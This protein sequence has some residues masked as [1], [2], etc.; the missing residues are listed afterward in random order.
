MNYTYS[1]SSPLVHP[2]V[3]P[4]DEFGTILQKLNGIKPHQKIFIADDGRFYIGG[5]GAK[6]R[7]TFRS[8]A[9]LPARHQPLGVE[10]RFIDFLQQGVLTR[11]VVGNQLSHIMAIAKRLGLNWGNAHN[12]AEH[13]ELAGLMQDII[14]AANNGEIDETSLRED[15]VKSF[16]DHHED[17]LLG[18]NG[19]GCCVPCFP[20]RATWKD[21]PQRSSLIG[22]VKPIP[23]QEIPPV[24]PEQFPETVVVIPE[25]PQPKEVTLPPL[26]PKIEEQVPPVIPEVPLPLPQLIDPPEESKPAD[27][28]INNVPVLPPVVPEIEPHKPNRWKKVIG[29][30]ALTSLIALTALGT[31]ALTQRELPPFDAK[32]ICPSPTECSPCVSSS[33][34]SYNNIMDG[35]ENTFPYFGVLSHL[36]TLVG[37]VAVTALYF[38]NQKNILSKIVEL[39]PVFVVEE[40]MVDNPKLLETIEALK[41][42]LK[43]LKEE[44]ER[45]GNEHAS[46]KQAYDALKQEYDVLKPK[47]EALLE[48][49]ALL[50]EKMDAEKTQLVEKILEARKTLLPILAQIRMTLEPKRNL[51]LTSEDSENQGINDDLTVT[52]KIFNFA[53]DEAEL[54][55]LS[56]RDL[57]V[58]FNLIINAGLS[59]IIQLLSTRNA[60]SEKEKDELGDQMIKSGLS[61]INDSLG[62]NEALRSMFQFLYNWLIDQR[63]TIKELL[64]LKLANAKTIGELKEQLK[65]YTSPTNSRKRQGGKALKIEDINITPDI[66]Q[67]LEALE[68]RIS[69][70]SEDEQIGI[71]RAALKRII[72]KSKA[73]ETKNV[74]IKQIK[75]SFK[76]GSESLTATERLKFLHKGLDFSP[77]ED[78]YEQLT[79]AYADWMDKGS[80]MTTLETKIEQFEQKISQKDKEIAKLIKEKGEIESDFLKAKRQIK[81]MTP[82][83]QEIGDGVSSAL[84]QSQTFESTDEIQKVIADK[85]YENT[86]TLLIEFVKHLFKKYDIFLTDEDSGLLSNFSQFL[87]KKPNTEVN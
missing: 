6:V 51:E 1:T 38:R 55:K 81:D 47:Y 20:E 32:C 78:K 53:H 57:L 28:S 37:G 23:I 34:D 27:P 13:F 75:N 70:L 48:E 71:L 60:L 8:M 54:K 62:N 17:E 61:S 80:K 11:K 18:R 14:K 52:Q 56:P 26:L 24:F 9:G 12:A 36:V 43:K 74:K 33:S 69:K 31:Y 67:K 16:Y 83:V 76:Q 85:D 77:L 44:L 25:I 7:E 82:Q 59:S 72:K 87:I 5:F 45:L 66:S 41:N 19:F 29:V 65:I 58:N 79:F 49:Y 35:K 22:R 73:A 40:K 21:P 4:I 64:A 50:K 68:S 84:S 2:I 30:A 10:Y 3:S 46:L 42:E 39:P 15:Y 63:N 86:R